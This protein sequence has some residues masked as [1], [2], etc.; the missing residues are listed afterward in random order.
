MPKRILQIILWVA[1][2]HSVAGQ[3]ASVFIDSALTANPSLKAMEYQ[4]QT[5]SELAKGAG[6]LPDPQL[7]GGVAASPIETRLGPQLARVEVRQMFPWFGTLKTQKELARKKADVIKENLNQSESLMALTVYK[8]YFRL[9][10]LQARLDVLQQRKVFIETHKSLANTSV[11]SGKGSVVDVIRATNSLDDIITQ[12]ELIRLQQKAGYAQFNTLINRR[13]TVAIEAYFPEGEPNLDAL[14]DSVPSNHPELAMLQQQQL[15]LDSKLALEQ[16]KGQ[17]KLGLALSYN[18]IGTRSDA[19]PEGNGKDA[20]MP[21]LAISLPLYRKKY[22]HAQQAVALEQVGLKE[23]ISLKTNDLYSKSQQMRSA[24]QMAQKSDAL[25]ARQ[26]QNLTHA[27]AIL[28]KKYTTDGLAFEEVIRMEEMLLQLEL[29][30]VAMKTKA[31]TAW[32]ELNY[33]HN[34]K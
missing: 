21:S 22:T 6:I 5:A 4:H 2:C 28:T 10:D 30:R 32:A 29:K 24:L 3:N 14:A 13:D 12:I 20:Y 23:R 9:C 18:L 8:Q 15:L 34:I 1:A 16:K 26:A 19:S 17:P 31:W 27:L 11:S 7:M 33:L 25:Y